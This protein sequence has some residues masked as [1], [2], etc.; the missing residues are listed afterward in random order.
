MR[1]PLYLSSSF[2]CHPEYISEGY[3]AKGKLKESLVTDCGFNQ[4]FLFLRWQDI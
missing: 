1:S 4:S 3:H 2:V